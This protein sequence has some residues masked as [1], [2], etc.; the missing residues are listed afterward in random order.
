MIGETLEFG[1][2]LSDGSLL[3]EFER[4][5]VVIVLGWGEVGMQGLKKG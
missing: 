1:Q 5:S 2:I 3:S 4:V